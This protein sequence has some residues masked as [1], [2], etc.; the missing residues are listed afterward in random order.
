MRQTSGFFG[1]VG[2]IFLTFAIVAALLTGGGG[3]FDVLFI[4][5]HFFAGVLALVTF[6]SSGVENLREFLGER[7]TRYGTSTILA[8]LFFIGILGALNYLSTRYYYR[9]DMTEAGVFS[10]SPQ[11][12]SII[13]GLDRELVMQAFVEA[14]SNVLIET[15]LRSYAEASPKV[16]FKMIDPERHPDLAEKYAIRQYNSVHITYGDQTTTVTEPSEESITNAVIKLTRESQATVCVIEGHGE[17]N[18]EDRQDPRG[19]AAALEALEN[20]N[21]TVEKVLLPSLGSLPEQCAVAL[22]AGPTRPYL[23][24][25]LTAL[26]TFLRGGGRALFILAPQQ[27]DELVGLVARWG[28]NVGRDIVVDQVVRLFQGPSL[29]VSPLVEDYDPEHEITRNFDGRTIFP[30]T[31]SVSAAAADGIS[32]TEIVKTSPSSWAESDV[33]ALFQNQTATLD[34]QDR[35]GPVAVAAAAAIDL[36]TLAEDESGD[37]RLVVF[38]SVQFADNQS[39]DGTFFNRDLLLNAVGWLAGE[40]DL[41]SIRPRAIRSSRVSFTQDEGSVVFYLA[42]LIIPEILL[43]VGIFVWWR[44]E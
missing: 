32:V 3:S 42:V 25:E 39:L 21:Y 15:T 7:S 11:S 14:G 26:D 22:I 29:G 24:H 10:L 31:R 28:I 9:V 30:L 4:G 6:L 8:S 35:G 17:P 1:L 2:L 36:A 19:L 23:E 43:L 33:D 13:D 18:L 20:E 34:P 5:F 38:G 37:A 27:A 41:L 40:R 44:R 16:S 12:K